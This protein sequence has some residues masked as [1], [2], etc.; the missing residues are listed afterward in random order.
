MCDDL[1]ELIDVSVNKTK[2]DEVEKKEEFKMAGSKRKNRQKAMPD[3]EMAD[4]DDMFD[5]EDDAVNEDDMEI[6]KNDP[7]QRISFPPVAPEKLTDGKFEI[8][9]IHVPS[10][11]FNPLKENWMKVYTPVVEYLKLQIRFNLKSRNVEI[12]VKYKKKFCLSI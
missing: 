12:K 3:A 4:Q 9:K 1:P 6:N 11:R 5:D 10:N 2:E 8:R 7:V